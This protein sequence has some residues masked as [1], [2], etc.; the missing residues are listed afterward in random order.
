MK[1][2]EKLV[3]EIALIKGFATNK[4]EAINNG[5]T[6]YIE[7]EFASCYGGYRINMVQVKNGAHHGALG[8]SSACPRRTKGKMIEYLEAYINGLNS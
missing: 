5:L 4:D 1:Q 2:I 6:E 3:S 8:E 7:V